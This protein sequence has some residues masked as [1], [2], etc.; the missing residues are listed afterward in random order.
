MKKVKIVVSNRSVLLHSFFNFSFFFCF[1]MVAD[2]REKHVSAGFKALRY[3]RQ[4][5]PCIALKIPYDPEMKA[6]NSAIFS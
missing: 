5:R 1:M 3:G 6:S 2:H 4:Q